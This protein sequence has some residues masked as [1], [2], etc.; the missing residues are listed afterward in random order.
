MEHFV[1]SHPVQTFD[2]VKVLKQLMTPEQDY[3]ISFGST[4]CHRNTGTDWQDLEKE[5]SA[6]LKPLS[7]F[8]V[9]YFKDSYRSIAKFE[10]SVHGFFRFEL[11]WSDKQA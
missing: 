3:T 8:T 5:I 4:I 11:S 6:R 9:T 1:D 7:D 10:K 2:V